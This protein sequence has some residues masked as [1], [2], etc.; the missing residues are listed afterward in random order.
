MEEILL[1]TVKQVAQA[2]DDLLISPPLPADQ[3][4]Y[5]L[6]GT[7]TVKVITPDQRVIEKS[8]DISMPLGTR[9]SSFILSFPN[10]QAA[11]IPVGSQVWV[12]KSSK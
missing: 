5:D 3:Y 7:Q 11:E 8:A 6:N 12:K 1:L 4:D 2:G 9:T 10:T